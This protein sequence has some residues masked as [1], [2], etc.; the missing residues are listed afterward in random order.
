MTITDLTPSSSVGISLSLAV[1]VCLLNLSL[2][3]LLL[4]L[5]SFSAG[6]QL[7][8]AAV[9]PTDS[10]FQVCQVIGRTTNQTPCM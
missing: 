9:R 10:G 4:S 5:F 3:F 1:S 7:N 6:H 8:S 2:S